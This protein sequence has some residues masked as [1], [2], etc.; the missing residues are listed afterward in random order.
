MGFEFVGALGASHDMRA[1]LCVVA[2]S[3][4]NNALSPERG[5]DNYSVL[6]ERTPPTLDGGLVSLNRRSECSISENSLPRI[7]TATSWLKFYL[8]RR[9]AHVG[10]DR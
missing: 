1:E 10:D 5:N 6:S 2:R 8:L 4:T 7:S 3:K 9:G